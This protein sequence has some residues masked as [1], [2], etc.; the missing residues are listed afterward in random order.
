MGALT[1]G[2]E[3][4]AMLRNLYE[5][6]KTHKLYNILIWIDETLTTGNEGK[7]VAYLWDYGH[8]AH[9]LRKRVLQLFKNP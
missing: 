3:V 5:T 7:I 8:V 2:K 6:L 4:S 1:E 9:T